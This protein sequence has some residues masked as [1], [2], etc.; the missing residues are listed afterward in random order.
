M[1]QQKFG[2]SNV[3]RHSTGSTPFHHMS[4]EV[5]GRNCSVVQWCHRS[6]FSLQDKFE[7]NLDGDNIDDDET[8][9]QPS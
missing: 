4:V 8:A 3:Y 5:E 6:C 2:S 9:L 1:S 7:R